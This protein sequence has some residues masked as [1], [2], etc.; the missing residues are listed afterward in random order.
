[1]G[2]SPSSLLHLDNNPILS[3][4]GGRSGQAKRLQDAGPRFVIKFWFLF[5]S[6]CLNNTENKTCD[7]N[8]LNERTAV[9]NKTRESVGGEFRQEQT[10]PDTPSVPTTSHSQAFVFVFVFVFFCMCVSSPLWVRSG[11]GLIMKQRTLF[12]LCMAPVTYHQRH[13]RNILCPPTPPRTTKGR[14]IS[15][16]PRGHIM[17]TVNIKE[18][19]MVNQ[20]P[21]CPRKRVLRCFCARHKVGPALAACKVGPPRNWFCLIF[22]ASREAGFQARN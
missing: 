17:I 20:N 21:V 6:N 7:P 4:Q 8:C 10:M 18:Y 22:L 5:G 3:Q 2:R 15:A 16:Q 1:M 11:L 9:C 13:Q 14:F 19:Q 12:G